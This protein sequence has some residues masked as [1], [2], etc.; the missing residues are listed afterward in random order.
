[1]GARPHDKQGDPVPNPQRSATK[2]TR[3]PR[4]RDSRVIL[5]TTHR[6][7][8]DRQPG[9]WSSA[10][11][12]CVGLPFS[13]AT[14]LKRH[15][16]AAWPGGR[17]AGWPM[18]PAMP[19]GRP[20]R[21]GHSQARWRRPHRRSPPSAETSWRAVATLLTRPRSVPS[22]APSAVQAA[23]FDDAFALLRG[24]VNTSSAT[25]RTTRSPCRL[26]QSWMGV[27]RR[28]PMRVEWDLVLFT[29][30]TSLCHDASGLCRDRFTSPYKGDIRATPL[31][32]PCYDAT[33]SV[34]APWPSVAAPGGVG[35]GRH[36]R[37][38]HPHPTPWPG[39]CP[40]HAHGRPALRGLSLDAR[41]GAS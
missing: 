16:G 25:D 10:A 8:Q 12:S 17:V 28:V 6:F 34:G 26:T 3:G 4:P 19:A 1:M 38:P 27:S 13:P 40:S 23:R 32:L 7:D 35:S 30:P 31:D 36:A 20:A 24:N 39:E 33:C 14:Q 22:P 21:R 29:H 41:T 18:S 11:A 37:R 5:S 15:L 2:P 9:R